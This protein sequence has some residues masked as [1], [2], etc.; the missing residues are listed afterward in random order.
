VNGQLECV[1][2]LLKRG[3]DPHMRTR[4]P[5][6]VDPSDGRTAAQ[7][8][9]SSLRAAAAAHVGGEALLPQLKVGKA[10]LPL[11]LV[12]VGVEAKR[13]LHGSQRPREVGARTAVR[14]LARVGV[15][16]LARE[17]ARTKARVRAS[18][19]HPQTIHPGRRRKQPK[20]A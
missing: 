6:G 18:Q 10:L 20:I 8:A 13:Q 4:S 3:V 5:Q 7:L 11:L 9:E 1:E 14:M 12:K 2:A 16:M 19:H 15:R 17:K